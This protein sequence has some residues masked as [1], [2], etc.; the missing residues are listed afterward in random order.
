MRGLA[1]WH[2]GRF[3]LYQY[4]VLE[5]SF[6]IVFTDFLRKA[7]RGRGLKF[8]VMEGDGNDEHGN[9]A[10]RTTSGDLMRFMNVSPLFE[11]AY[12]EVSD[13]Y[14]PVTPGKDSEIF[15]I[16]PAILSKG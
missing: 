10:V 4:L 16:S 5:K 11:S 13:P 15:L 3:P 9:L 6:K 14:K 8:G 1:L 12:F 2:L 7:G